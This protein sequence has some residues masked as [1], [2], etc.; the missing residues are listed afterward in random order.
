MSG[1]LEADLVHT[2]AVIALELKNNLLG[3]LDVLLEDGLG[4]TTETGLLSVV[5]TL[6]YRG[7]IMKV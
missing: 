5:T 4:L 7:K 3:S 1:A 2:G 6:T